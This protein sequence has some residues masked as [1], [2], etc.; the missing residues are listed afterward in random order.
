MLGILCN[1]PPAI[2][3]TYGAGLQIP[4]GNNIVTL[5]QF[6]RGAAVDEKLK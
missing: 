1:S 4:P 2:F 3:G 5:K 6:W